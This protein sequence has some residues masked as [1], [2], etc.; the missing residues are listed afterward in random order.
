[1]ELVDTIAFMM[2]PYY[3]ERFKGEYYQLKIR[4]A[5]LTKMVNNWDNLSFEPT[6]S[7]ETYVTQLEAMRMYIDIL[8]LRAKTEGIELNGNL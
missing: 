6:C 4:Y 1:M 5:K 8:E 3:K 7:K 2:S